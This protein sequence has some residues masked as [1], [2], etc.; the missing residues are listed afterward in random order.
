MELVINYYAVFLAAVVS[1]VLGMLWYGPVFGKQWMNMM[2]YTPESMKAM[3]LSPAAA[4]G[5]MALLSL[6]MMYVLAHA[7]VFG[8]AYTGITGAVGGMTGA[9]YY[10][11]GFVV[12]LTAGPFLWENK[13]PKLWAFNAAYY[14]VALLAAGAILGAWPG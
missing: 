1:F 13:S 4:M 6:I 12:P 7:V 14:L 8:I 5:V 9:F 10:W 3:K 11:L 2:G